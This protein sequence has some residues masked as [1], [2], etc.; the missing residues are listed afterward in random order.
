[1]DL[2]RA[3]VLYG[4]F[5][6]FNAFCVKVLLGQKEKDALLYLRKWLKEA[7]RKEGLQPK[8]RFKAGMHKK[9]A[10]DHARRPYSTLQPPLLRLSH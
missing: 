9:Q 4:G 10:I 8:E 1:M 6:D 3:G 5:T 2:P 7:L